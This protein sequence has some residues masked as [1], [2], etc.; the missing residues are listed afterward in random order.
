MDDTTGTRT[1]NYNLSG[2]LELQNEDL[3]SF[4]G[5]RRVIYPRATS[6]VIGRPTGLQLG[7]SGSPT[8]DQ[9][10][11]YGYDTYGRFNT[12]AGGGVTLDYT[13]TTNSNLLAGIAHTASGWTQARTY[14]SNRDLLD[15][16]ETKVSTTTKGK[17]DYGHDNLGRRTSVAKTGELYSRYGNGTQGLDTTWG[18]DDRS[19]VTSEL[20]KLGGSSTVLTGRDDGYAFDNIGN[21]SSTAGTTH[22]SNTTN[23]TTNA[24]NQ[25]TQRTV[26]AYS[27]WLERLVPER[28]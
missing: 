25:Y 28:P 1:F 10:V 8:A 27:M 24:L 14:L 16:I 5:T 4:F 12:F 15:V 19:Q 3:P 7:T 13:Y 22:N 23:Y 6:G 17:F 2:T 20:T 11:T 9:S 18:Y 21:R 26:R